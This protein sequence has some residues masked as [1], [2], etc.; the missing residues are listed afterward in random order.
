[1]DTDN[2]YRERHRQ[3]C[4]QDTAQ[5]HANIQRIQYRKLKK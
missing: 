3:H 4:E 1:M 2:R 5:R